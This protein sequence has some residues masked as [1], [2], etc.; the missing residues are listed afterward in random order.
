MRI[1]RKSMLIIAGIAHTSTRHA[2][3]SGHEFRTKGVSLL[4]RVPPHPGY[5]STAVQR[6]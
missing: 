2:S 1:L 4:T 6:V 3:Y 5:V